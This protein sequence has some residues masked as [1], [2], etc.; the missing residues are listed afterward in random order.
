MSDTAAD[1]PDTENTET[2]LDK[3]DRLK[4]EFVAA[5]IGSLA[6]GDDEAARELA[7]RLH[8]ADIA[9]LFEQ[10][11]RDQRA[12]L[13]AVLSEM[14]DGEVLAEMNDFVRETLVDELDNV[15]VADLA[16]ISR[17]TMPLRSSRIWKLTTSAKS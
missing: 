16:A 13:A 11:D 8:P 17:P 9:D 10:L 6:S 15:Q 5:V 1:A 3:D 2:G 4:P 12:D 7:G 14:L